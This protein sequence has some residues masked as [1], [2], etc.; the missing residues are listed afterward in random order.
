MGFTVVSRFLRRRN[1]SPAPSPS[2]KRCES[3]STSVDISPMLIT[4]A[5]APL[6]SLLSSDDQR[7]V[8]TKVE[9]LFGELPE[10]YKGH[11]NVPAPLLA[12]YKVNEVRSFNVLLSASSPFFSPLC[13][14]PI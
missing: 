13:S 11:K 14:T 12:Y 4:V 10:R 2:P 5:P 9:P 7:I 1:S 8:I 3:E 6:V